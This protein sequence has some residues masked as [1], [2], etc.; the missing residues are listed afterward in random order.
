MRYGQVRR[1]VHIELWRLVIVTIDHDAQRQ[2]I[3]IT[4]TILVLS[5]PSIHWQ[6]LSETVVYSSMIPAFRRYNMRR[7][8]T[9]WWTDVENVGV[10]WPAHLSALFGLA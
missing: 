8:G 1:I 5:F 4:T 6:I 9:R 3:C 10:T 2:K 7:F